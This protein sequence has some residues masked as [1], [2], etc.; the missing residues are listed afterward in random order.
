[1]QTRPADL[2]TL[3]EIS[4]LND[5]NSG[6][7]LP[8]D[9]QDTLRTRSIVSFVYVVNYIAVVI[10]FL[11]WMHKASSNLRSLGVV[12]QRYS[13]HAAVLWWFCPIAWWWMPYFALREIWHG[14][15]ITGAR[16]HLAF[17]AWWLLW[18]VG[19][20]AGP[21]LLMVNA[22]PYTQPDRYIARDWI[23][24]LTNFLLLVS[25][26]FLF[27]IVRRT[28]ENQEEM[29]GLASQQAAPA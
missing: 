3:S 22:D 13:P 7:I 23:S 29:A 17:T 6:V 11:M 21:V 24:I 27:E 8:Q 2:M 9:I 26:W 12:N 5:L 16:T 25:A 10:A 20:Y 4:L 14:S 1:M 19:A 18:C 15:R 28:T